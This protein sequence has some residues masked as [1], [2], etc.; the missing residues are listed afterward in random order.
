MDSIAVVVLGILI[1]LFAGF[2]QGLTSFGFALLSVPLLTKLFPLQQVVPLVVILSLMTNVAVLIKARHR[3]DLKKIWVLIASS[4]A[5]APIGTFLLVY[6]DSSLLKICIGALIIGFALLILRGRSFPVQNEKLAFVPVGAA[7]G[8]LNGTIGLS[9]PPVALFLS[10]QGTDKQTFRANITA[11]A[12]ILNAITIVTYAYSGL[13]NKQLGVYIGWMVPAL[14]AGVLAGIKA[15][16]K[17]NEKTFKRLALGLIL[18]SGGWTLLSGL[19]W[20]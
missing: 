2:V 18:V 9:G 3:V 14:I 13:L 7:S 17:L 12:T 1:V 10:N 6:I 15:V 20:V 8:L 4:L 19:D 11:Y 16:D 5:A